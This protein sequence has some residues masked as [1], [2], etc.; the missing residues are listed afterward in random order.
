MKSANEQ[1][2]SFLGGKLLIRNLPAAGESADE[3]R[4]I[5]DKGEMAQIANSREA[6]FVHLLYWD[7]KPG[8]DRGHHYH[9]RKLENFYVISGKLKLRIQDNETHEV[10]DRVLTAGMKVTIEPPCPHAFRA[11]EYSQVLE[12]HAEPYNEA[13]TIKQDIEF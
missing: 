11:I 2:R 13:D 12:F 9:K 8:F 4:I 3:R 6:R 1:A 5:Q 7:L 10:L